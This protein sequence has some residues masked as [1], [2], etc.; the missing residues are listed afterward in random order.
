MC[1][2]VHTNRYIPESPGDY[3]SIKFTYIHDDILTITSEQ[4]YIDENLLNKLNDTAPIS[5]LQNIDTF[6]FKSEKSMIF[7]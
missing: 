4:C 1:E 2:Y 6:Y 5:I 7:L 3:F